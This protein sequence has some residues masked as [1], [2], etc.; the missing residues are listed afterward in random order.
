MGLRI[1]LYYM[2]GSLWHTEAT[3]AT[4]ISDVSSSFLHW[5]RLYTWGFLA[6]NPTPLLAA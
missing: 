4:L 1:A 3:T 5:R 2:E 6:Q